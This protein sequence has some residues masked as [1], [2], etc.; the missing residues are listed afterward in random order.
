MKRSVFPDKKAKKKVFTIIAPILMRKIFYIKIS[1]LIKTV[2]HEWIFHF[3]K[4][5]MHFYV[6]RRRYEN[7]QYCSSASCDFDGFNCGIFYDF[8]F[9]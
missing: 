5:R 8:F 6:V 9:I 3:I 1:F 7:M 4:P 2:F